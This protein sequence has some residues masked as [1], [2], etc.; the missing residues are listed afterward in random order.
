MHCN[1]LLQKEAG[2]ASN[3][4]GGRSNI[5]AAFVKNSTALG[6]NLAIGRRNIGIAMFL[7]VIDG[8]YAD[9]ES[10][11]RFALGCTF[12]RPFTGTWRGFRHSG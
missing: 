12:E 6:Y 4:D 5:S 10:V 3:T 11:R 8:Y 2:A 1:D 9:A 7:K